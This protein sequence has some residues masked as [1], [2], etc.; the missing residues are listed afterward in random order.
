MATTFRDFIVECDMYPHS[1]EAY[2][3]MKECCELQVTAQFLENQEFLQE[4]AAILTDGNVTFTEG[5]FA[6]TVDSATIE[7]I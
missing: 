2:E 7:S 5:Y 6:E 1:L 4:N 3:L